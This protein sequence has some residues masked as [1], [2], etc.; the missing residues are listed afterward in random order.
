MVTI[1][2]ALPNEYNII[3]EIAR[4]TW[5]VAYRDI[6]S[7]AQLDY[8]LELFYSIEAIN[9]NAEDG[10]RFLIARSEG[11]IGGF[12]SYQTDYK[13]RQTHI[14]KI[15]VLPEM[16]G[17]Q[18]GRELMIRIQEIALMAGQTVL[19]LNVNRNN[20]AQHFYSGLGFK[21]VESTDIDIGHGYLM[22]DFIMEKSLI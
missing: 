12:A 13:P 17:R 1:T 8:M 18:V 15:Y 20:S 16:Q 19:S 11:Q 4:R 5:P 9:Q 21:V 10:H 14:Q 6:L 2:E 3:Q 22:E 7:N